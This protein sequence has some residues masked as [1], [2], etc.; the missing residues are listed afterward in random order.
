MKTKK[1]IMVWFW[2]GLMMS[3]NANS[4][5]QGLSIRLENKIDKSSIVKV[6]FSNSSNRDLSLPVY[7]FCMGNSLYLN[8]FEVSK[9]SGIDTTDRA[10]FGGLQDFVSEEMI[11]NGEK[12]T[13]AVNSEFSCEV[14]LS[15]DYSVY[16]TDEFKV[17][18][19]LRENL[20]DSTSEVLIRSNTVTV[21]LEPPPQIK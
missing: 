12:Q 14:D 9:N 8:M 17:A 11:I 5:Y 3:C 15:V 4:T 1:I 19:V 7:I 20:F 13:I 10:Y 18:Y 2:L 16:Q 6:T 21:T